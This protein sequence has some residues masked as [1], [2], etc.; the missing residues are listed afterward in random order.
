[1]DLKKAKVLLKSLLELD[2]R[3]RMSAEEALKTDFFDSI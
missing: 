3:K 2:P 1:M